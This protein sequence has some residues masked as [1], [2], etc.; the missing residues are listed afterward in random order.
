MT[1]L[2][3]L[4]TPINLKDD[5]T[6]E[7][8]LLHKYAILTTLPF[9]KHASPIFAQRKLKGR[10]RLLVDLR[11]I[12]N[13]ITQEYANNNHPVST[14]SDAAQHMAG[15]SFFC[16]LDCSHAY[17]CLRMADYQSLKMLTFNFSSRTFAYRR[18]VQVL[19]RSLS[20]FSSFMREYLDKAFEPK[21]PIC[22]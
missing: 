20:A 6:E 1:D 16:K 2:Q 12:N 3:S 4:P 8:A 14:L 21:C 17:H 7:L 13:V 9:S 5:I 18:L 22:R 11:K 19:S 10:L 15:K